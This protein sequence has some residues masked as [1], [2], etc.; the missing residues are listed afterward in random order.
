M[1]PER[2]HRSEHIAY[3]DG[4]RGVAA[5]T[6]LVYHAWA[7]NIGNAA[8]PIVTGWTGYPWDHILSRGH[9][10]VSLFLV[11]S[12]FCLSYP[13][14]QRRG[15]GAARWFVPSQFFAR[16]CLRILP[17]YYAALIGLQTVA[18]LSARHHWPLALWPI[19]RGDFIFHVLLLHNMT[20]GV[21][22]LN[23]AFWSLGLEWQWYWVFPAAL[24]GCMFAPRLTLGIAAGLAIFWQLAMHNL[25]SIDSIESAALPG[26]L[27]EFCCGIV[28]AG[29][30]SGHWQLV[31]SKTRLL[32]GIILA[33]GLVEMPPL[34]FL[35]H[36]PHGLHRLGLD[37]PLWG[38]A[39]GLLLV[40]GSRSARVNALFAWRPLV[41]L[42]GVSYS[43]YLVHQPIVFTLTNDAPG[44]LRTSPLIVLVA[45]AGGLAGGILFHWI[46]E[47][48]VMQRRTW[49]VLGPWLMAPFRWMDEPWA[50]LQQRRMAS[51]STA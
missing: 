41:A 15:A 22:S 40:L 25:W 10:G 17:P 5:G 28:A 39:W 1:T 42:G 12:G 44:W 16:R 21:M 48:P 30:V 20:P 11:L 36:I 26:R 27:F 43:V 32:I 18:A 19:A 23:P 29:V 34:G 33:I 7:A 45:I 24:L 37:Q 4:L 38:V 47:R 51:G 2:T 35:A 46:V 8:V 6:V 13:L 50:R 9:E 49:Q 14:W 31:V 3:I